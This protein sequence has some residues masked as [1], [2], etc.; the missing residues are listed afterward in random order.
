MRISPTSTIFTK[1][2]IIF[3][4]DDGEIYIQSLIFIL[5]DMMDSFEK[6]LQLSNRHTIGVHIHEES[7]FLY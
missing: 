6:M 2:I 1:L 5:G 3:I 7:C 4:I